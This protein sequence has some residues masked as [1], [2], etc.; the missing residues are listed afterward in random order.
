M[1]ELLKAYLESKTDNVEIIRYETFIEDDEQQ[2]EVWVRNYRTEAGE[3]RHIT[4]SELLV[5]LFERQA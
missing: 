5:F 2:Y 3:L 4:V 1:N